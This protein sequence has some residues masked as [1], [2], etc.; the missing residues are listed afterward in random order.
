MDTTALSSLSTSSS[1]NQHLLNLKKTSLRLL[2]LLFLNISLW[3]LGCLLFMHLEGEHETK[4]KCGVMRVRRNFIEDLWNETLTLDEL[5]WKSLARQKL[6]IFE[7]ELH[8]AVEAGVSTYS[9]QKSWT[10][11]NTFLYVFTLATTIG[12]GHLTPVSWWV[13]LVSVL[14]GGLACPLLGVLVAEIST[15]LA[16]FL[17]VFVTA[18]RRN[19]QDCKGQVGFVAAIL[20]YLIGTESDCLPSVGFLSLVLVSYCI[21]GAVLFS[22]VFFWNI[23]DSLYFVFSSVST[24]GFGDIVPQDS[25]IFLFLGGYTLVGMAIYSLYQDSMMNLISDWIA[26]ADSRIKNHMDKK[27]TEKKQQ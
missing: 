15:F 25:L 16:T 11:A 1:M 10:P 4:H 27:T 23:M 6:V 12:Y 18:V 22:V 2:M 9:G 26:V 21:M 17:Q 8:E 20:L 3:L 24:V 7:E 5:D 13:R 19:N 14:F